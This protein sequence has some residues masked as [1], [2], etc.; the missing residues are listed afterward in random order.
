MF[1]NSG[2]C[3]NH[4]RTISMNGLLGL[5]KRNY[6]RSFALFII[7]F[8]YALFC[9]GFFLGFLGPKSKILV[10]NAGVYELENFLFAAFNQ[11]AG[12]YTDPILS[13]LNGRMKT[14]I[15][16]AVNF[17]FLEIL[18]NW[19]CVM[20]ANKLRYVIFSLDE[21]IHD[22]L[23]SINETSIYW[24]FLNSREDISLF[25][26]PS[27]NFISFQKVRIVYEV[28]KFGYDILFL[29]ADV[30]LLSDPFPY[31]S[32]KSV[33]HYFSSN[34]FCPEKFDLKNASY[35]EGNTGFYFVRS[36][37]R[38]IRIW[39]YAVLLLQHA[40]ELDDQ[41]LFWG[42]L[43]D[44]SKYGI[45]RFISPL[46]LK[47][48][49]T[50]VPVFTS[51]NLDNCIFASGFSHT[52]KYLKN[53]TIVS[54]HSN[55]LMGNEKIPTLQKYGLWFWNVSTV[56]CDNVPEISLPFKTIISEE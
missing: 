8:C 36:N 33:D 23:I 45:V 19:M 55:F 53:R 16:T 52:I 17:G 47:D 4:V 29:D 49:T 28:L 24:K 18:L 42:L 27:F 35:N 9:G 5:K 7:V 41:T 43:R 39:E 48:N 34:V 6:P 3:S 30:I 11:S 26:H 46:S 10:V 32:E 50:E 44:L 40:T 1:C 20:K 54:L 21:K 2:I 12:V 13:H 38:S 51:A 22:Y 31:F 15:A 56:E 25:R 14:V 37:L